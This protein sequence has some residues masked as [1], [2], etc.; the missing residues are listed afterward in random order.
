MA[1][2]RNLSFEDAKINVGSTV[3]T[4]RNVP[5]S[6]LDLTFANKTT[7]DVYKKVD[8]AAVKQAVKTI[9][10]TD[11]GEK[12]FQ[13]YFGANIRALLFENVTETTISSNLERNIRF[14]IEKYEPRAVVEDVE[15]LDLSDKNS[16]YAR[17]T[18]TVINTQELVVLDT[19]ISRIR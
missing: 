6:D 4:S 13:P 19:A 15:I 8:A 12:P 9:L 14:A 1:V 7:G 5:Y 18:F 16:V 10:Q 2:T 3:A 17:I 11:F